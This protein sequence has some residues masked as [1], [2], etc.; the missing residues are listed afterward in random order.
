MNDTANLSLREP[1]QKPKVSE[2]LTAL[3]TAVSNNSD[4]LIRT[5]R[6]YETMRCLW[7]GKTYDGKKHL[8]PNNRPLGPWEGSA[9]T[10][11]RLAE[12]L[13]TEKATLLM[14]AV[15]RSKLTG[16]PREINDPPATQLAVSLMR[17]YFTGDMD[18]EVW[19]TL[20]RTVEAMLSYGHAIIRVDWHERRALVERPLTYEALLDWAKMQQQQTA[21]EE[22]QLLLEEANVQEPLSETEVDTLA[23]AVEA[24]GDTAAA[25]VMAAIAMPSAR[26]ELVDLLR[27][28]DPDMCPGE[29]QRLAAALQSA[30]ANSYT[31]CAAELVESRPQWRPL[32]PWVDV[33][34]PGLAENLQDEPFIA[35]VA[36]V[37]EIQLREMAAAEEWNPAFLKAVLEHPGWAF[38][39][40][41]GAGLDWVLA[42]VGVNQTIRGTNLTS[43]YFQLVRLTYKAVN[44]GGVVGVWEMMV[45]SA[46]PEVPAYDR[47][48]QDADGQYPHVAFPRGFGRRLIDNTG[49]PEA[50]ESEQQQLKTMADSRLDLT[51]LQVDPP[52]KRHWRDI[53]QNTREQIKPGSEFGEREGTTTEFMQIAP[54]GSSTASLNSE[55]DILAKVMRR[56]GM[57][58][59]T[60]PAAVSQMRMEAEVGHFFKSLKVL[61]GK[62]FALVQQHMPEEMAILVAGGP[63]AFAAGTGGEI[64]NVT[65]ADIRGRWHFTMEMDPR[66]LNMEWVMERLQ[67]IQQILLLDNLAATDRAAL[68]RL[69]YAA[70]DP[71]LTAL[72][73]PAEA[74]AASEEADELSAWA[75]IAAGE[76][77]PMREGVDY[78]TRLAVWQRM[79][80][81]SPRAA[82]IIQTSPAVQKLA[83]VRMKYLQQ[84]VAQNENKIIGRRGTA[85]A[86]ETP[87]AGASSPLA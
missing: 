36:W 79:L 48:C 31:Y 42:C 82:E 73:Q 78:K 4:S 45:H 22:L 24:Q 41:L 11:E 17:Y 72:V 2:W 38:D 8:D 29:P 76:E 66:D 52:L 46:S 21:L 64:I 35:E 12:L 50:V 87:V 5:Q 49:I 6:A 74:A 62:T 28:F 40:N 67:M 60:V 19:D 47:L 84:G 83:E 56:F 51:A 43:D 77:P 20:G 3:G 57:I 30:R 69:A 70:I 33:F 15:L 1:R 55:K 26:P 54:L 37:N 10:S 16:T 63:E 53:K 81:R 9:D 68:L 65:R 59:P 44:H 71:R 58:D 7:G 23:A 27:A 80:Q 13:V 39:H 32:L 86:F 14:L 34:T 85:S 61:V 18:N 25:G 75:I